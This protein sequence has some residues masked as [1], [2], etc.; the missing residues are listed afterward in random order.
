MKYAHDAY[1]NALI[2]RRCKHG[3][4]PLLLAAHKCHYSIIEYLISGKENRRN[5][6]SDIT[7]TDDDGDT[8][9]HLVAASLDKLTEVPNERDSPEIYKVLWFVSY[10]FLQ[11]I[12]FH[13]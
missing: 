13:F 2:E 10:V 7:A 3:P 11:L 4:T 9:V 12:A 6:R 8:A 1:I 5:I